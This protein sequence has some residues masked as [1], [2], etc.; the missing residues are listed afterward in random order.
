MELKSYFGLTDV[1]IQSIITWW[2]P[3]AA[4][5]RETFFEIASP[6]Y[7]EKSEMSVGFWQWA[8]SVTTATLGTASVVNVVD[9]V[10]G[11]PEIVYWMNEF[12]CK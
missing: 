7:R 12:L 5:Y 6:G 3:K 8:D 2:E 1:Q 4:V 11:Y 10:T 9:T